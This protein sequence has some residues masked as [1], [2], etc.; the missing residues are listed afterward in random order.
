MSNNPRDMV[1]TSHRGSR[2]ARSMPDAA[3]ENTSYA[4]VNGLDDESDVAR[5]A[6]ELFVDRRGRGEDGSADA[7]WF[8]AESEVRRTRNQEPI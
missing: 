5:R 3:D 7:D 4:A 1:Q 8:R 6:Y 2:T